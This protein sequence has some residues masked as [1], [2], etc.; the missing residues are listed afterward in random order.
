M[1]F[2]HGFIPQNNMFFYSEKLKT[3]LSML[4][5]VLH[6]E[7]LCTAFKSAQQ[8]TKIKQTK[9]PQNSWT[10]SKQNPIC[11]CPESAAFSYTAT[12][13]SFKVRWPILTKTT[14]FYRSLTLEKFSFFKEQNGYVQADVQN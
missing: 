11:I 2:K 1:E 4:S 10:F 5:F 6:A 14:M 8:A 7:S 13:T 9:T 3:A 12:D